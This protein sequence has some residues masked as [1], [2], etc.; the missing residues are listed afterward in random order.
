LAVNGKDFKSNTR[1][2]SL[3]SFQIRVPENTVLQFQAI[4]D[5]EKYE[6]DSFTRRTTRI[7]LKEDILFELPYHVDIKPNEKRTISGVIADEANAPLENATLKITSTSVNDSIITDASGRFEF[8]IP[9]AETVQLSAYLKDY[10]Y[11]A[12]EI[13]PTSDPFTDEFKLTLPRLEK[14]QKY[15]AG[16]LIFMANEDVLL[17]SSMI[18]LW[19][20]ANVVQMAK[21]YCFRIEGHINF[22]EH[23]PVGRDTPDFRLS[24]RRAKRIY[25][26]LLDIGVRKRRISWEGYGNWKMKYPKAISTY[27]GTQNRRVEVLVFQ[28]SN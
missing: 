14:T 12:K 7:F 1:T 4:P 9:S 23:G 3:G 27:E 18:H 11:A 22:P 5:S 21:G 17:P 24:E 10:F 25:N 8:Q 15:V 20:L 16:E 13:S 19:S 2:D 6:R 28:C 26:F